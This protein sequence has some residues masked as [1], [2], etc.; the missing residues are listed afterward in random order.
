MLCCNDGVK[1][2]KRSILILR[3]QR[4]GHKREP[5]CQDSSAGLPNSQE[6]TTPLLPSQKPSQIHLPTT[7]SLRDTDLLPEQKLPR[8]GTMAS[9]N[10]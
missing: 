4:K 1:G 3:D 5:L 6:S 10:R 7:C 9:G 8:Y 2:L